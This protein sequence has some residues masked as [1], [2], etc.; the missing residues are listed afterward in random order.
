[1]QVL[2]TADG[3]PVDGYDV[4]V[5]DP[6]NLVAKRFGLPN[7]CRLVVRPDGYLGAITALNDRT[8]VAEYF[9]QIAR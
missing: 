5:A 2:V 8:G 6:N 7:G 4:V 1:M 9:A 3:A